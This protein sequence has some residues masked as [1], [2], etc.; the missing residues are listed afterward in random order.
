MKHT[1]WLIGA[2]LFLTTLWQG[3]SSAPK[4]VTT[5][6]S[7]KQL[8]VEGTRL[9]DGNGKNISLR[10]V[11]FGWHNWWPRFYNASCVKSLKDDWKCTLV[12][13]A[14]GVEPEGAYLSDPEQALACVTAV[15]D[16]AIQN[17]MY[18]I[19]DW[20]SHHIRTEE[21]KTFFAE[22][23]RRY[24]DS[25]YV[26]YEIFNEPVDDSWEA[27]KAYSEEVI[28]TIRAIDPD[29]LILVGCPHWDQDVHLVADDP[30]EGQDNIMY[31]LHFYAGTHGQFL[32]DR[33]DYAL[34]K[35]LPLF[36]S[37]CGGMEASGNG[38]LAPEEWNAWLEWMEKNG[39]SWAAW[40]ISSKDET[41]SMIRAE[42]SFEGNWKESELKEWGKMVR[43]KL[44]E[45][46]R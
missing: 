22:M 13:A 40:S 9:V 46:N 18:V 26:I 19:I 1:I 31:T 29:N 45:L 34:Q 25:P 10:G 38:A 39:I 36:V 11:S 33:G 35:G 20:H 42:G 5:N 27:V 30:I 4:E 37:E 17:D 24:G 28:R 14:M 23:A 6:G 2:A 15:V 8:S 32:R 12:R 41:C 3:C 16:A 7:E 44:Q 43:Q 21:A